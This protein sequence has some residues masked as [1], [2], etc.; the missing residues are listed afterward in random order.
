MNGFGPGDPPLWP[1]PRQQSSSPSSWP[2]GAHSQGRVTDVRCV[3]VGPC[4]TSGWGQGTPSSGH[5]ALPASPIQSPRHPL[6]PT[7]LSCLLQ[8]TDS[9]TIKV[10]MQALGKVSASLSPRLRPRDT[11]Q[12]GRRTAPPPH[13][14]TSLSLSLAS[15]CLYHLNPPEQHR[16]T[17]RDDCD[18]ARQ[19]TDK[20][21]KLL[22]RGKCGILGPGGGG[23]R[24]PEGARVS[25]GRHQGISFSLTLK[26]ILMETQEAISLVI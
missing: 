5:M 22:P 19:R 18:R 2:L 20:Q 23:C 11:H 25:L 15:P 26:P 17:L 21:A 6:S 7:P 13:P 1:Q 14:D 4:V 10:P 8:F 24:G 16:Q 12:R 9:V 3:S